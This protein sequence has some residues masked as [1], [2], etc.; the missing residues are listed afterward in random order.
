MGRPRERVFIRKPDRIA[1][2]DLAHW[3]RAND[4]SINQLSIAL[5]SLHGFS[6][7]KYRTVEGWLSEH[8]H[9]PANLQHRINFVADHG[10]ALPR[11]GEA[12]RD[13]PQPAPPLARMTAIASCEHCG[14]VLTPAGDCTWSFCPGNDDDPPED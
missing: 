10:G 4:I 11:Y 3:M 6:N 13:E 7:C 1:A 5:S 14:S 12:W 2:A 8:S 9:C